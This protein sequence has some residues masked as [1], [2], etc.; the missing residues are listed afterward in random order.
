MIFQ[1]KC[2]FHIC[3]ICMDLRLKRNIFNLKTVCQG[4]QAIPQEEIHLCKVPQKMN[5]RNQ[6]LQRI[7]LADQDLKRDLDLVLIPL[8]HQHC[9]HLQ[10]MVLIV[11]PSRQDSLITVHAFKANLLERRYLKVM[12]CACPGE[13]CILGKTKNFSRSTLTSYITS[14]TFSYITVLWRL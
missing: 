7:T 5:Q 3:V 14:S 2:K 11:S 9:Q 4:L 13:K 6:Y 8:L 12:I 1:T 10:K